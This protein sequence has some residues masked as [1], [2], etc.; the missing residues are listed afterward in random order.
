M[1]RHIDYAM[2]LREV[3]RELNLSQQRVFSLEKSALR[4]LR[5]RP[6]RFRKFIELVNW[7]RGMKEHGQEEP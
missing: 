7:R 5:A 2:S 6:A 4:K 1:G 3:A